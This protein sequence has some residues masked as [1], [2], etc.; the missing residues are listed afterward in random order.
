[1]SLVLDG[2]QNGGEAMN[3]F[4][5]MSKLEDVEKEKMKNAL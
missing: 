5:N 1:M 2:V 3:A 4:A